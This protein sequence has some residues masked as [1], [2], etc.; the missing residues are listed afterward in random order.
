MG[1]KTLTRATGRGIKALAISTAKNTKGALNPKKGDRKV[2]MTLIL[3]I[4]F[5]ILV[6]VMMFQFRENLVAMLEIMFKT[7]TYVLGIFTAGN[8]I[9][10]AAEGLGNRI[11]GSNGSDEP[12]GGDEPFTP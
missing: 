11:N 3:V 6:T 7:I 1:F 2:R 5:L 9:E 8:G 4:P 10:H 12:P